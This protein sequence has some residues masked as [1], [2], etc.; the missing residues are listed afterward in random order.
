MHIDEKKT[1]TEMLSLEAYKTLLSEG[2]KDVSDAFDFEKY[3]DD[4]LHMTRL[5]L[6]YLRESSGI[7]Q[8]EVAKRLGMTQS[9]VSRIERGEGDIGMA[10]VY[11]YTMA[12]GLRPI[13][14]YVPSPSLGAAGQDLESVLTAMEKLSALQQGDFEDRIG[15]TDTGTIVVDGKQA[16]WSEVA[17]L[18]ASMSASACQK[19]SLEFAHILSPKSIGGSE[20]EME[21]V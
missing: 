8:G 4:F 21:T 2:S 19:F 12:L 1:D 17:D 15:I 11:R 20:A 18:V 10:T 5:Q 3:C 16:S 9:A 14:N 6:K 13:V 7:K